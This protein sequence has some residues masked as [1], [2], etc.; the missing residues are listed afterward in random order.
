MLDL[1]LVLRYR[2]V[3]WKKYVCANPDCSGEPWCSVWGICERY[4]A[5]QPAS[6]MKEV[7]GLDDILWLH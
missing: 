3:E 6:Q 5:P 7:S 2:V 1:G 4:R